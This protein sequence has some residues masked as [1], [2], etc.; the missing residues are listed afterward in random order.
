MSFANHIAAF[1]NA[2]GSGNPD[3]VLALAQVDWQ[4]DEDRNDFI[5]SLVKLNGNKRIG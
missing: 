4:S 2:L 5:D 1:T 3:I